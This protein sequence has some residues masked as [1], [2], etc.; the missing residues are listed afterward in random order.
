MGM[1]KRQQFSGPCLREDGKDV[2]VVTVRGVEQCAEDDDE[3]E[4]EVVVG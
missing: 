3:N 4:D 1:K 2:F